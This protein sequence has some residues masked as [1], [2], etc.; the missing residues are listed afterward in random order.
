[1]TFFLGS[2]SGLLVSLVAWFLVTHAIRPAMGFSDTVAVR[3]REVDGEPRRPDVYRIGVRNLRQRA[4][5]RSHRS[6][7]EVTYRVMLYC[8]SIEMDEP[9]DAQIDIPLQVQETHRLSTYRMLR[10]EYAE[11][12]EIAKRLPDDA[13]T[14]LRG[15]SMT[16][17][18]LLESLPNPRPRD[19]RPSTPYLRLFAAG[20]DSFTGVRRVFASQPYS[21]SDIR[22]G[23]INSDTFEF[24]PTGSLE[25]G[26]LES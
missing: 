12:E 2:L 13:K 21:V 20:A 19:D 11:C 16:L 1:M 4:L 24:V 7:T 17:E 25:A 22:V 26:S 3:R 14:S 23:E 5:F 18:V 15:G 9:Y 8:G 10:I 6:V